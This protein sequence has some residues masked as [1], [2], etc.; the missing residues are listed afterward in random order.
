MSS[1]LRRKST[2]DSMLVSSLS[3]SI[4]EGSLSIY[5]GEGPGERCGRVVP[6]F[7]RRKSKFD[8]RWVLTGLGRASSGRVLGVGSSRLALG[9]PLSRDGRDEDE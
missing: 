3:S 1:I 4:G 2:L 5:I 7:S 8:S 6:S 9:R